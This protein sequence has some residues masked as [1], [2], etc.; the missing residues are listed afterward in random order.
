M[1]VNEPA[2]EMATDTTDI[3]GHMQVTGSVENQVMYD[4][5]RFIGDRRSRVNV[6]RKEQEA[7]EQG[8]K[9]AEKIQE[10]MDLINPGSTG[11]EKQPLCKVS[12]YLLC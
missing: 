2:F 7:A 8:S 5:L 4:D 12:G 9:R 6:L 11:L 3:T 10:E 1:I